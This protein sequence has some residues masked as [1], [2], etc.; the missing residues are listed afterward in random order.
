MRPSSVHQSVDALTMPGTVLDDGARVILVLDQPDNVW[1]ATWQLLRTGYELPVG[2]LSGGMQAWRTSGE[3]V[4]MLDEIAV[5]EIEVLDVRQPAE[6]VDGHVPGARFITGA[7]LPGRLGELDASRPTAVM[8]G[9]GYR[10][11]VVSS[12]LRARGHEHVHNVIGGM[13]AW[14]NAGLPV[15]KE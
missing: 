1:E 14:N 5:R 15:S 13:S 4:E 9:S 2:W 12:L 8:C 3:A 7:E 6:W 10:S 11:A